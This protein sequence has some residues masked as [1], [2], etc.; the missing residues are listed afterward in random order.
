MALT[1]LRAVVEI[2]F[3]STQEG[4]IRVAGEVVSD[5]SAPE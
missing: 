4:Q 5:E 2:L 1:V 3:P